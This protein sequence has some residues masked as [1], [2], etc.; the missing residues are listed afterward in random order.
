LVYTEDQSL[1]TEPND[2]EHS[3]FGALTLDGIRVLLVDDEVD[4]TEVISY[5]LQESGAIVTSVGSVSEALLDF[6]QTQPDVIISDIAMPEKDGYS[7]IKQIRSTS[8]I[9]R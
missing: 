9:T 4:T 5:T 1:T 6:S 3:T 2:L 7:L 8:H